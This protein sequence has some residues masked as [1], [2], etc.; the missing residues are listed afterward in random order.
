MRGRKLA[1]GLLVLALCGCLPS[2]TPTPLPS[3]VILEVQAS[4]ALLDLKNDFY[5]CAR[6]E[7]LALIVDEAA[8]GENVRLLLRWGPPPGWNGYASVL[9]EDELALVAHPAN[10]I[11][12]LSL[13][14]VRDLFT[15][16]LH[17]WPSTGADE[18]EVHM[19]GYPAG[20]DIRQAYEERVLEEPQPEGSFYVAPGPAELREGVG[21][22]PS[23]LGFLPRRWVNAQ[24][25]V[26]PI[27]DLDPARLRLPVLALSPAQPTE[28]AAGWLLCVQEQSFLTGGQTREESNGN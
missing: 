11:E 13:A 6:R 22:D 20:T 7:N 3:P 1:C 8:D 28:P 2:V 9:G 18:T 19:W 21:A 15:G 17:A 26:L 12:R 5:E 14:S 24:V 10:P 23:A 25:K 4:A 16:K 27:D